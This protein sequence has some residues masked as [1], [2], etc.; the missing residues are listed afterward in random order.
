MM[1][2]NHGSMQNHRFCNFSKVFRN[3]DMIYTHLAQFPVNL[4]QK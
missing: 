1:S 4:V 3:V 2:R